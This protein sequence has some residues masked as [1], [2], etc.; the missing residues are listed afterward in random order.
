FAH[1]IPIWARNRPLVEGLFWKLT[2]LQHACDTDG[3]RLTDPLELIHTGWGGMD[4]MGYLGED[5]YQAD[6]EFMVYESPLN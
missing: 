2:A 1:N 6:W 3:N 5:P 4:E